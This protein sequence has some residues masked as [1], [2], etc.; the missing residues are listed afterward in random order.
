MKRIKFLTVAGC[1][2]M[3]MVPGVALAH[4]DSEPSVIAG[5]L[6]WGFMVFG[7]VIIAAVSTVLFTKNTVPEGDSMEEAFASLTGFSG[8][9]AKMRLFSRNARLFIVHVVGMD[10]IYGTWA[11]LFNLYLLAV[12]FDIKF[13]GLRIMLQML[14]ASAF[15]IPAGVISDRVGRKLSFIIGDGGGA[16]MALIAISTTD[17]T[18]LLA[19]GLV[20]GIFGS[21][22]G[23][24]EPAFM[25]ENSE[26]F[27]RVHLF[28]VGMGT[29]MA[30]AIIGSALAGLV[31]LLLT[32]SDS[33]TQVET[34]RLVAYAGI[35]G[36]FL[37]LIPAAMLR[38]TAPPKVEGDSG[39][40]R[41]FFAGIKHPDR[42]W[43][44]TLPE[45]FFAMGAGFALP[46]MNVFFR[47]GLGSPEVE[48]GAT[49]A[50]GQSFLVVGAFLAPLLMQQ[51]PK[52]RPNPYSTARSEN[53]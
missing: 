30:A 41:S 17:S 49:F 5:R 38:Q 28:S 36:W 42:V 47:E 34:Y 13:I 53:G 3:L 23:V 48:I 1:F 25:A 50:A 24:A 14:A 18:L 16:V 33:A 20:A 12:G 51:A 35:G 26:R 40:L 52:K 45:V 10:V 44:L 15:S 43:K 4:G 29:R 27:E 8:Y 21:M 9:I 37:S 32:G 22:H 46:L 2:A 19:T 39:G 31:P 11:V 6:A 7:A